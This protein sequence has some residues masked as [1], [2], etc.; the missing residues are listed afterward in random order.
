MAPGDFQAYWIAAY[1]WLRGQDF[2][3]PD[4]L[5]AMQRQIGGAKSFS[6]SA[7]AAPWLNVLLGPFTYLPFRYALFAWLLCNIV[8]IGVSVFIVYP[9]GWTQL[10]AAF[11]FPAT[12]LSLWMGQVN[13]LVLFGLAAFLFCH[14]SGR[15]YLAG[16]ALILVTIKPHLALMTLPLLFL[17]L[18]RNRN[19]RV[20]A[21]FALALGAS[22]LI[23]TVISAGWVHSTLGLLVEGTTTYRMT[24]T[25]SGVL[26]TV[27]LGWGKWLIAPALFFFLA[28]YVK[29]ADRL[30]LRQW[31]DISIIASLFFSPLGWSYDQILLLIPIWSLLEHFNWGLV[32]ALFAVY[33]VTFWQRLNT[34]NDVVFVWLPL[35]VALLVSLKLQFATQPW[36]SL[37]SGSENRSVASFLA[38]R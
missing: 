2:S 3:N 6:M 22:L 12:L 29:C 25:L 18:C 35:A 31:L 7:F 17:Y 19:W 15:F 23:L 5:L 30:N 20:L 21:G 16:A 11:A 8:L 24:P 14:Q 34:T 4:V 28:T 10:F 26:V 1:L 36:G 9:R 37:G 27:G 33:A 38:S 13:T 32:A